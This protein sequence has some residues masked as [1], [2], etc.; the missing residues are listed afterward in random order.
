MD[1]SKL[2][3]LQGFTVTSLLLTAIICL[4]AVFVAWYNYRSQIRFSQV[5]AG[6]FGYLLYVVLNTAPSGVLPAIGNSAASVLVFVAV[7]V[8]II[9]LIRIVMTKYALMPRFDSADAGIGYALGFAG[10]YLIFSCALYYFSCY[11][12][13]RAY[14]LSGAESFFAELSASEAESAYELLLEVG[15]TSG[16][17]FMATA[18]NRVFYLVRNLFLSVLIWYGLADEKKRYWLAGAPILHMIAILPDGLL[19]AGIITNAMISNLA[20]CVLSFGVV[21][22]GVQEYK[23]HENVLK[24]FKL[25]RLSSRR[26][27]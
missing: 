9:E 24:Q 3:D 11:T 18:L 26:H 20:V 12:T 10:F 22:I 1:Y 14:S 15:G 23:A 7:D 16:A 19:R 17:V 2:P 5:I 13:V 25:E 8:I 27:R 21:L 4:V 6:A